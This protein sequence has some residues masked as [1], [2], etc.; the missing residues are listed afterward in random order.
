MPTST[1]TGLAPF[2]QATPGSYRLGDGQKEKLPSALLKN[3]E[4]PSGACVLA[5]LVSLV[6]AAGRLQEAKDVVGESQYSLERGSHVS[7]RGS[8]KYSTDVVQFRP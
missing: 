4:L 1:R 5:E 8:V 2:H 6:V 3:C 7:H